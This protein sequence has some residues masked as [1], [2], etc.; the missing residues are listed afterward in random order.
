MFNS[1]SSKAC[2]YGQ[3]TVVRIQNNGS[4]HESVERIIGR[5]GEVS[6]NHA[7]S[8]PCMLEGAICG[9][10]R[11]GE[12][13]KRMSTNDG[14]IKWKP[15]ETY[16][17]VKCIDIQK[18]IERKGR[19]GLLE[20]PNQEVK[21]IQTIEHR[22]NGQ[23]TV[24]IDNVDERIRAADN[25][26]EHYGLI[27][28][29]DI[30]SDGKHLFIVMP[31]CEGGD[32][33]RQRSQKERMPENEAKRLLRGMLRAVRT[34]NSVGIYHRDVSME[35]VMIYKGSIPVLIDFG[36]SLF[37]NVQGNGIVRALTCGKVSFKPLSTFSISESADC[38]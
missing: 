26:A 4:T 27:T 13:L 5:S 29:I 24:H 9:E 1:I 7:Y 32:L 31:Y 28:S 37:F 10:V 12:I 19:D 15:T 35:N 17:A 6:D 18:V 2:S 22:L 16:V 34:L 21:A 25:I 8:R 38:V 14:S 33:Q 36:L 23:V 3:A 30:L 11:W 20:D